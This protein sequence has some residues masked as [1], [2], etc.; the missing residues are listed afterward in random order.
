[1]GISWW[2]ACSGLKTPLETIITIFN[3][4]KNEVSKYI[5]IRLHKDISESLLPRSSE[6]KKPIKRAENGN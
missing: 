1:M 2:N 4:E 6:S 3:S 5:K